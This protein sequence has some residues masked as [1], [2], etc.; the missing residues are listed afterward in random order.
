MAAELYTHFVAGCY[1]VIFRI[2]KRIPD[3]FGRILPGTAG[4]RPESLS[5]EA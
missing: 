4:E 2:S 5:G 1:I 3:T